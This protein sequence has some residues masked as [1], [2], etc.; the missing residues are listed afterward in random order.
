[1]KHKNEK[2]HRTSFRHWKRFTFHSSISAKIGPCG[3]SSK[4]FWR[5]RQSRV[6]WL[7]WH[8][9]AMYTNFIACDAMFCWRKGW[10]EEP[11]LELRIRNADVLLS[12]KRAPKRFPSH[13]RICSVWSLH[14]FPHIPLLSSQLEEIAAELFANIGFANL[15]QWWSMRRMHR[16]H[17]EQW[18]VRGA[19]G[20]P[21]FLQGPRD[22]GMEQSWK[23]KMKQSKQLSFHS[24]AR[25]HSKWWHVTLS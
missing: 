19:F 17:T 20:D 22:S 16:L 13:V 2:C 23:G 3:P 15:R 18:W 5:A 10:G 24:S 8:V 6:L 11:V 12:K 7:P 21:H 1:M 25:R 4:P 9:K 14:N